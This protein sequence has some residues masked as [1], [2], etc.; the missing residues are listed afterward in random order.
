[1]KPFANCPVCGS[2]FRNINLNK[3]WW[4]QLC[5]ARCDAD[6][7]QFFPS[8]F[9]DEYLSYAS[10]YTKDFHLYLYFEHYY[11]KDYCGKMYVYNRVFPR[12][13]S[14]QNVQIIAK[15]P[16]IDFSNL[17]KLNNKLKIWNIFK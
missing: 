11:N 17:D 9:Q 10:F 4:Q 1:M 7:S 5:Q 15:I 8:S 13:E 12:G 2:I 6:F 16:D 14:V 3:S